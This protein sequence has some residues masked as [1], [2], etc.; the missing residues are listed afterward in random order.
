MEESATSLVVLGVVE[1]QWTTLV[2]KYL[3]GSHVSSPL[4]FAWDE[5]R[6]VRVQLELVRYPVTQ[7]WSEGRLVQEVIGYHPDPLKKLVDTYFKINR[8]ANV[9][10]S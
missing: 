7:V 6:E 5:L 4:F 3:H 10:S 1:E 8:K 9:K 2:L